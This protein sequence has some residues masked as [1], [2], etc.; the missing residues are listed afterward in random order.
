MKRYTS[1]FDD[2]DSIELDDDVNGEYVLFSDIEPVLKENEELKELHFS[3][4][5]KNNRLDIQN[6]ELRKK[7][8]KARETLGVI[9]TGNIDVYYID[10]AKETLGE[11]K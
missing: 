2:L 7:L 4:L 6:E 9:V 5:E 1:R 10:L 8:D 11:L 3:V